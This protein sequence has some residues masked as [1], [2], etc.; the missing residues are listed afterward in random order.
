MVISIILGCLIA[1]FL[2]GL[3]VAGVAKFAFGKWEWRNVWLWFIMPI[4]AIMYKL[5][6]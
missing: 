6:G 4:Q 1:Y 2:I 3:L 5:L